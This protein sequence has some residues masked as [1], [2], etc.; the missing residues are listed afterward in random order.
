M[1][2]NK[3][4]AMIYVFKMLY[5]DERIIRKDIMNDLEINEL[6]FRRYIQEIRSYLVNF[7]E[8]YELVYNKYEDTYFLRKI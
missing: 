3:S 7:D 5:E 1:K 6:T 4:Q 8:P 2:V